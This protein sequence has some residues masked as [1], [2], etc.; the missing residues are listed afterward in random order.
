[1]HSIRPSERGDSRLLVLDRRSGALTHTTFGRLPRVSPDGDRLVL[2][3]T[4][5]FPARLLGTRVP[6]GGGVECLLLRQISSTSS[7]CGRMGGADAPGTEA[8]ARGARP[9]RCAVTIEIEGEVLDRAL[10]Q[11]DGRCGC[12]T[13]TAICSRRSIAIGHIPLPPYIKRADTA[14]DRERYQTVYAAIVGIDCRT[15]GRTALHADAAGY[16]AR[17]TASAWST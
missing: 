7:S 15:D 8:E 2:N 5:V 3:D 13:A 6:S 4:R 9:I 14:D 16:A 11:D 17:R 12:R 1:M 10:L